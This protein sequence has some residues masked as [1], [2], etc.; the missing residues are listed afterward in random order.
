MSGLNLILHRYL[1][2]IS[3]IL[4]LL[5]EGSS[6]IY[7]SENWSSMDNYKKAYI[8]LMIVPV[9]EQAI[10]I[11]YYM[12]PIGALPLSLRFMIDLVV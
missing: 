11:M 5:D 6:V 1:N 7:A 9:I 12:C 10:P 8:I 3:G 4:F 2:I